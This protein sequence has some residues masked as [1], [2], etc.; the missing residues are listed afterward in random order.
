MNRD[1]KIGESFILNSPEDAEDFK[2]AGR[3]IERGNKGESKKRREKRLNAKQQETRKV[4]ATDA[5]M[6]PEMMESFKNMSDEERQEMMKTY[7][8][9]RWWKAGRTIQGAR[10]GGSGRAKLI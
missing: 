3:R 8:R 10:P 4:P 5:R 2:L 1:L 6:T 7:A 9:S